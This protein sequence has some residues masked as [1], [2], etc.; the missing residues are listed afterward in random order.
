MNVGNAGSPARFLNITATFSAS[1]NVVSNFAD[2]YLEV[3][4]ATMPG[5]AELSFIETQDF[6]Q[7]GSIVRRVDV[8]PG[9]RNVRL[10]AR[11]NSSNVASVTID[12]VTRPTRDHAALIVLETLT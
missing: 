4:G 12:P 5:G 1:S 7:S 9:V 6:G 8:F 3:D 10:M 2:F 11:S